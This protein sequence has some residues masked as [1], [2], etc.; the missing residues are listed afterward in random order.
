MHVIFP[1]F[2]ATSTI[3]APQRRARL[4][5]LHPLPARHGPT[6][7]STCYRFSICDGSA[8]RSRPFSAH[9]GDTLPYTRR[10]VTRKIHETT[11]HLTVAHPP[12]STAAYISKVFNIGPTVF[13]TTSPRRGGSLPC[14]FRL[15]FFSH[16]IHALFR[17]HRGPSLQPS[18][19]SLVRS[20]LLL[21]IRARTHRRSICTSGKC[22]LT[23]LRERPRSEEQSNDGVL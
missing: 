18:C 11:N 22:E 2:L 14:T 21:I 9:C 7:F 3:K 19:A 15:V 12:A 20:F 17:W 6:A 8:T 10:N 23:P 1:G 13:I 5:S 4:P 16:L